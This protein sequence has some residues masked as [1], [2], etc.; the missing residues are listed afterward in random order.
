M[1]GL[2][3]VAGFACGLLAAAGGWHL[4][5]GIARFSEDEKYL[6]AAARAARGRLILKQ[7]QGPSGNPILL[8]KEFPNPRPIQ[9]KGQI[10][11]LMDRRLLQADASGIPGRFVLTPEG[12]RRTQK[13]PEF[14]LPLIRQ[15]SW[16]NSISRRP[17]RIA[18]R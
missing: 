9:D 14:P 7:D 10:S 8:L 13:L 17:Q 1:E 4:H 2:M 11:R 5:K 12:W 3:F 18:R 15:G 16:F 6:L